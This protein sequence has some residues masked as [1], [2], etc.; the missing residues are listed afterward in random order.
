MTRA[1]DETDYDCYLGLSGTLNLLIQ[2]H[3]LKEEPMLYSMSDQALGSKSSSS[4]RFNGSR[5]TE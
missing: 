3:N 5:A 4:D 1:V 2:Q